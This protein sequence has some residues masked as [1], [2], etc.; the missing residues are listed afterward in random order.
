M[1]KENLF[2]PEELTDLDRN[3]LTQAEILEGNKI[4]LKFMGLDNDKSDKWIIEYALYDRSWDELMKVARKIFSFWDEAISDLNVDRHNYKHLMF[5]QV[6][7]RNDFYR[8]TVIFVKKYYE[9]YDE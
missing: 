7:Y 1:N 3:P 4:F 2:H 5:H 9:V 6:M 8:K